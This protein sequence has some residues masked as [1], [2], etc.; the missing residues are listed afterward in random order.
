M[1]L[2]DRTIVVCLVAITIISIAFIAWSAFYKGAYP[3]SQSPSH[4]K[5]LTRIFVIK[6]SRLPEVLALQIPGTE[7]ICNPDD[8]QLLLTLG[9]SFNNI[10]KISTVAKGEVVIIVDKDY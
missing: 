1:V 5:P 7:Y 4:S 2:I 10:C 8:Y 9:I 6:I 3:E